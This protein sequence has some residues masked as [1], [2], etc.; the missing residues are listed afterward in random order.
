MGYY[1]DRFGEETARSKISDMKRIG[2]AE[3]IDFSYSGFIG[4]TLDSHRLIW[5]AR[6]EGG[7]DLQDRVVESVFKA[8]F[9]EEKSLGEPSVLKECAERAGMDVSSVL[10][11]GTDAGRR[12]VEEEMEDFR[13]RFSCSGV[14]L[15][16]V[17][18]TYVLSGAQPPEA[19]LET[20]SKLR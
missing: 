13:T 4:N 10:R 16:V 14:P 20:F 7:S 18:G 1:V 15:F 9:E 6:E 12:E 5:K 11:D 8:Y 19:F 2:A 3:K 17:D